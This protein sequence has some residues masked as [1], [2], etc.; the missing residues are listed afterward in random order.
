MNYL[1]LSDYEPCYD[2]SACLILK[3]GGEGS[4]IPFCSSLVTLMQCTTLLLIYRPASLT[5]VTVPILRIY[6]SWENFKYTTAATVCGVHC[7]LQRWGLNSCSC[8]VVYRWFTE[9]KF[10]LRCR[11][12]TTDAPFWTCVKNRPCKSWVEFRLKT[13]SEPGMRVSL[14][15][16]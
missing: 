12:N 13:T 1:L 3:V 14:A 16:L 4:C 6:I 10:R 11:V 15:G 7:S 2:R 5:V 9:V 8:S